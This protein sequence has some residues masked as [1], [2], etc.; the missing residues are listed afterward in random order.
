M[1]RRIA[2]VL[3]AFAM[4]TPVF[5]DD[6][7]VK[8]PYTDWSKNDCQ[9]L[10]ENSPW[11]QRSDFTQVN[12]ATVSQ[13]TTGSGG[14]RVSQS[15]QIDQSAISETEMGRQSSTQINYIVQFR[16]A[17]P[18]RQAIVRQL[19]MQKSGLSK[20]Q[21]EQIDAQSERFLNQQLDDAVIVHV[22]YRSA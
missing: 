16:S 3:L 19:Q 8:K 11:S 4:A 20:E 12:M 9:K 22:I 13:T 15:T 7:W 10:L 18:V 14:Q 21:Q 5:G 1:I 2:L 6:F 17:L